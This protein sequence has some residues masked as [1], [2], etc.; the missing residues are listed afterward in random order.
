MCSRQAGTRGNRSLGRCENIESKGFRRRK[1]LTVLQSSQSSVARGLAIMPGQIGAEPLID[2]LVEQNAH[3]RA[4]EQKVLGF[5]ECGER[6][7]AR[8]GGKTLQKVFE[9]FATLQVVEQ[10]LDRYSGSTKNRGACKDIRILDDYAH[11]RILP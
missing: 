4:G 1:N 11:T 2:A 10:S 3:L 8:D 5:Y 7:F 9:C 6:R